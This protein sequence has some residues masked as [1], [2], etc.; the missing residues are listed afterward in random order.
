[1][2]TQRCPRC[3]G[4]KKISCGYCS[5]SWEKRK[6]CGECRGTGKAICPTCNGCGWIY[7]PGP[8]P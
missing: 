4:E 2:A 1:M 7:T 8:K 3:N 5:S 6:L